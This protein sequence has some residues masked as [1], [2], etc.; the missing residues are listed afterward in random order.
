MLLG[1][2]EGALWALHTRN[3]ACN[4]RIGHKYS[5]CGRRRQPTFERCHWHRR[6]CNRSGQSGWQRE[7]IICP[8]VRTVPIPSPLDPALTTSSAGSRFAMQPRQ[9][10][11]AGP[12]KHPPNVIGPWSLPVRAAM[13]ES[14]VQNDVAVLFVVSAL[15]IDIPPLFHH[16]FPLDMK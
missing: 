1:R 12:S 7:D 5:R 14:T 10:R 16:A 4:A 3:G 6:L 11:P 13:A 8:L 15:A 9:R 2:G